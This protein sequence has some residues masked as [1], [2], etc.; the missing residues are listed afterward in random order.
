MKVALLFISVF[1]LSNTLFSQSSSFCNMIKED[2]VLFYKKS[3]FL[4]WAAKKKLYHLAIELKSDSGCRIV[5]TGYGN[6]CLTCQQTSWDRVYTVIKYIRHWGVDST[7]FV[8]SY[9]REGYNPLIVSIR[10]LLPGETGPALEEPPSP[11]YSYH[12]FHKKR[13]RGKRL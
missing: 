6:S 10:S 11:C 8:F 2:S 1:L 12:G 4:N 9:A 13:C 3:V 5:V 7:R